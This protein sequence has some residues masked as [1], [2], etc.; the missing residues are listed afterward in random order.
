MFTISD[1]IADIDRSCAIN[2]MNED[3][4]KYRI[5]FFA[6]DRNRSSKNYIDTTYSGLRKTLENIIK[7]NLTL[8]NCVVVTQTTVW[9][10]GKCVCLLNRSYGFCLNDYFKQINGEYRES[11]SRYNHGNTYRKAVSR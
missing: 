5:V 3:K 6:N 11:R 10:S 2:N 4:F 1:I 7:N 9:K 8:T